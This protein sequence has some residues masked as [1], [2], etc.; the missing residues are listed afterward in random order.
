MNWDNTLYIHPELKIGTCSW[1]YDSWV[2]LVYSKTAPNAAR[3][4]AEYARLFRT[5]EIDSWFYAVP[6]G[7]QVESYRAAVPDTFRFTCKVTRSVT[8]PRVNGEKNNDFLSTD[9]M[10]AYLEAIEPLAGQLDALMFEF[11]YLNRQKM[12]SL[13]AFIDTF[14]DFVSQLPK[15]FNYAVETRNSNYLK[16]EYFRFLK[17]AGLIHVFSEKIYMPPVY[18]VYENFPDSFSQGA[19]IRLLGGDRKK[20]ED[21]TRNVWN[22][23]VEPRN[24]LENIVEMIRAIRK[25]NSVTINVNNHYEG[26]A[27]LTIDRISRIYGKTGL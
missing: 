10:E 23:I 21:K 17:E 2:G 26:S 19:V 24:D 20:I 18:E 12:P 15:G 11:E 8:R 1:N 3:Y 16:P 4:L 22:G 5:V 7:S 9:V 6:A 25:I 13:Q 27:P 14:G